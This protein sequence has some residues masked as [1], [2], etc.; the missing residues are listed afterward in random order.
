MVSKI[1]SDVTGDPTAWTFLDGI[2]RDMSKQTAIFLQ[3]MTGTVHASITVYR[4][5]QERV[6]HATEM[7]GNG[8]LLIYQR[9]IAHL[10]H[11]NNIDTR[12]STFLRICTTF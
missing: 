10:S 1:H 11:S 12:M 3:G 6:T 4:I 5:L 9:A 8:E 2:K 7:Y